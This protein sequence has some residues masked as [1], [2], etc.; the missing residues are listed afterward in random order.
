MGYTA[1]FKHLYSRFREFS[2]FSLA[3]DTQ[4]RCVAIYVGRVMMATTLDEETEELLDSP[5]TKNIGW[6]EELVGKKD[7]MIYYLLQVTRREWN[8][9]KAGM[10]HYA[11]QT[12]GTEVWKK[13]RLGFV[14][15]LDTLWEFHN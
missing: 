5:I 7:E 15:E 6:A 9:I 10:I 12:R 13:R 4:H 8:L 14:A 1:A 2:D 11:N 3:P